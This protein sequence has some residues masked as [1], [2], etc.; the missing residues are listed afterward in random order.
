LEKGF[1]ATAGTQRPGAGRREGLEKRF[2]E[3]LW[4]KSMEKAHRDIAR[5]GS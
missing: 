3:G 1:G 4:K 5:K 2:M